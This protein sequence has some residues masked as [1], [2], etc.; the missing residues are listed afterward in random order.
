MLALAADP[1]PMS[2]EQGEALDPIVTI[3]NTLASLDTSALVA[4]FATIAEWIEEDGTRTLS[5]LHTEMPPWHLH[6]LLT[7]A[8]DQ[9][10]A[11]DQVGFDGA[12]DDDADD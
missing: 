5:I 12:F 1:P 8:R 6:G 11:Y 9:H 2:E 10:Q 7:Y 4:G 3:Q